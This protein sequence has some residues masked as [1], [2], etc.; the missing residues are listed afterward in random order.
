MGSTIAAG[1]SYATHGEPMIPVYI[2]Y[3]MFGFQRTGDS[4]WAFAD[5]LGRG[6]L[7][8]ATAGRTT[9][10]GEGLQHADGHSPL[11]AATNPAVRALRP[12]VRLRDQPHHAGRPAPDV[13]LDR[14]APAR[15]GRLLLPHR[16][17]R[18]DRAAARARGR[19][20]RRHPARACTSA[21]S[22]RHGRRATTGRAC[23][24]SRR[25]SRVPWAL[26]AQRLLAEEWQVARRRVVG[27]LVE[28][29]G[30]RRARG[31]RVEPAAPRPRSHGR[32]TSPTK[33]AG[34]AGPV[35]AVQRLHA[36]GAATRSPSGCRPTGTRSAPTASASPTPGPRRG[37]SSRSTPSRSWS[38]RSRRWPSAARSRPRPCRRRST[39]YRIDDPTAVADVKQEG[40]G[41]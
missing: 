4:I 3:S 10:T 40:A 22:G 7:I 38:R 18:A 2:F 34:R 9:L 13:R 33:L 21:R 39:R 25:A 35:L 23:S 8:G 31:R 37:G 16:L 27:D 20:R 11:I 28:R 19:R 6:F 32:R 29:A 17:Q 30:P 36:R 14:R 24:C 5:Q 15:R 12:G 41:A 26:K 1:T